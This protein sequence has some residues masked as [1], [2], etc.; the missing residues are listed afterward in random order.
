[1]TTTA[2]APEPPKGS[3]RPPHLPS[4]GADPS[5]RGRRA[6]RVVGAVVAVVTLVWGVLQVVVVLAHDERTVDATFDGTD[7]RT[8]DVR[9]DSGS[10]ILIGTDAPTVRVS[11]RIEDGLI[12]TTNSERL[13]DGRLEVRTSCPPVGSNFCHA[14]YVVEVPSGVDVVVRLGDAGAVVQ[15]IRGAVDVSADQG[16]IELRDVDGEVTA[17]SDTGSID[18]E[19]LRTARAT[20]RTDTGGVRA[21]FVDEPTTV[22]VHT[23]TGRVDLVV[24]DSSATYR[25]DVRSRTGSV[26]TPV[27]TD[28]AAQRSIAVRTMT[29]SV[30]VTYAPR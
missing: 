17:T 13:E 4:A 10:L 18:A 23:D 16:T 29:G 30:T 9:L 27:R 7:L 6:W 1:M 3:A 14:A 22:D 2:T 25:L 5:G 28:P 8:V 15:G 19:G 26:S 11:A 24:P 21:T 12:A 20:F